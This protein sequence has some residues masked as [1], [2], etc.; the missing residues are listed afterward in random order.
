VLRIQPDFLCDEAFAA[1][2][3]SDFCVWYNNEVGNNGC[4]IF[5]VSNNQK[6]EPY[7]VG[8]VWDLDHFFKSLR[9][10]LIY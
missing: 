5:Y 6:S 4:K 10:P 1:Y 9:E 8:Y 7:R 3:N 2:S